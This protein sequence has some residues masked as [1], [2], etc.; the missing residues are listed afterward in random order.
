[1]LQIIAVGKIRLR[2]IEKVVIKSYFG[3]H[4]R[5]CIHPVNGR[6]DLPSV[7]GVSAA[8]VGIVCRLYLGDIAVGIAFAALTADDIRRFETHLVARE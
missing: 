8:A 6:L 1:M 2:C 7:G 3:I 4:G 5:A